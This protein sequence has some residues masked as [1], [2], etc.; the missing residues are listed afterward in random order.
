[1]SHVRPIKSEK[2]SGKKKIMTFHFF[3]P[4]YIGVKN[5]AEFSGFNMNL[6]HN[7]AYAKWLKLFKA[8]KNIFKSFCIKSQLFHA[9]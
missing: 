5:D 3:T 2:M 9:D 8:L 6:N 1:M 4:K 7:V